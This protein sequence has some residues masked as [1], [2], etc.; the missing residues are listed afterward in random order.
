V[1]Y[2]APSR[3]Q[4]QIAVSY[5]RELA[6]QGEL[7][8]YLRL[9][10]RQLLCRQNGGI[11]HS[12]GA[13]GRL[14]HGVIPTAA[15]IDELWALSSRW[16]VELYTAL[17]TSLHKRPGQAYLLAT[18]TAGPTRHGKLWRT[19]QQGIEHGPDKEQPRSGLTIVRNGQSGFLGWWYSAPADADINDPALWRA[20]NP[21]PWIPDHELHRLR[22]SS[23]LSEQ[24]FRRLILNQWPRVTPGL[25]PA[26]RPIRTAHSR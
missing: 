9:G 14:A 21:A 19:Y 23:D 12:L 8:H 7:A 18:T 24:E 4:A 26:K 5:A 22:H 11:L 1:L 10:Q 17:A 2:G 16:Q 15:Y 13:D 25:R 6:E 3:A 20:C